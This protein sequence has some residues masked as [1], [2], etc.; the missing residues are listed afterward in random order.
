MSHREV[1]KYCLNKKNT[2]PVLIMEDDAIFC[3]DFTIKIQKFLKEVPEDWDCLMIGGFHGS[4]PVKKI[5]KGIVQCSHTCRLH[6]YS[7]R[8]KM[9]LQVYERLLNP[10]NRTPADLVMAS[11]MQQFKVYAPSPF[12]SGQRGGLSDIEQGI[13]RPEQW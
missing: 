3:P 7:L 12:L 2:Q 5:T 1:I 9:L 10:D 8:G 6:C 13:I 4:Y 11:M